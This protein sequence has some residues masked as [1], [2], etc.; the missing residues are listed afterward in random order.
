MFSCLFSLIC[1]V[2]M[3]VFLLFIFSFFPYCLFVSNSQVIGCE[4]RPWNDLYCVGRGV[5]L[6]SLTCR[7]HHVN[8]V[9]CLYCRRLHTPLWCKLILDGWRR[10]SRTV[11]I[12]VL[13]DNSH[14][15]STWC[16]PYFTTV[17]CCG[18]VT[19]CHDTGG[20]KAVLPLLHGIA[21]KEASFIF[22]RNLAICWDIFLQ[23]LKY[24]DV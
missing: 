18:F 24:F 8:N 10:I 19:Y 12:H 7:P 4:D 17:I 16:E 11:Q 1:I 2:F 20:V 6:C 3:R 21:Q 22:Q 9:R 13:C 14:Q 15:C 5:K 23:F